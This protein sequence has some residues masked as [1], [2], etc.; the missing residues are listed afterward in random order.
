MSV[1]NRYVYFLSAST[2]HA[3][4]TLWRLSGK[5][6]RASGSQQTNHLS[7]ANPP[8]TWLIVFTLANLRKYFPTATT[9]VVGNSRGC[10][11]DGYEMHVGTV[12]VEAVLLSA[13]FYE[14]WF[15]HDLYCILVMKILG[16]F[17][18]Y[19]YTLLCF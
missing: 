16:K 9:P 5:R 12:D 6:K 17:C 13:N 7:H 3:L 10:S 8:D 14:Y 4:Y 1:V 11:S 19:S 2:Q 18:K 15:Y